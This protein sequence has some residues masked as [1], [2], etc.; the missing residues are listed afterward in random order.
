MAAASKTAMLRQA[1]VLSAS[2]RLFSSTTQPLRPFRP[3]PLLPCTR[4]WLSPRLSLTSQIASFSSTAQRKILPPGPQ[5][6]QGGV[7]DPAPVPKPDPL[8]G[9]YHWTFERIL[10]V[11]LVPLTITPFAAGSVSPMLDAALIFG[12]LIH[13]HAGFQS[14][15]IDYIPINRHPTARRAFMWLLNLATLVVAVGFYEFET[16]DVGVVEAMKRIW[17]AGENDATIGKADVSNLGHDGK[18]KHLK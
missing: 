13:S 11:A 17:H 2:K 10:S 16:N 9:S 5:V 4:Q 14:I 6:I 15:I 12:I 1:Q 7:N 3:A 8:H 18:L